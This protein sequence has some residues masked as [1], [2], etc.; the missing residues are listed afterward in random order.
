MNRNLQQEFERTYELGCSP[1]PFHCLYHGV[2]QHR[3]LAYTEIYAV[4]TRVQTNQY[5]IEGR[6]YTPHEIEDGCP[7]W[8]YQ[9][10]LEGILRIR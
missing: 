7:T 10:H 4:Q 1:L 5:F 6:N 2:S 9:E 8:N 3:P